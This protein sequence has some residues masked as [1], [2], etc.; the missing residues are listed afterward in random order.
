MNLRLEWWVWGRRRNRFTLQP[1]AAAYSL[2]TNNSAFRAFFCSHHYI[3]C[4]GSSR[5]LRQRRLLFLI[6][7]LPGCPWAPQQL[8][9]VL[10]RLSPLEELVALCAEGAAPQGQKLGALCAE[11]ASPKINSRPASG[12]RSKASRASRRTAPTL[13]SV[14]LRNQSCSPCQTTALHISF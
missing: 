2:N 8:H 9:F 6:Q 14:S 10:K 3:L 13:E 1:Q 7:N 4:L 5:P 11:R 12:P